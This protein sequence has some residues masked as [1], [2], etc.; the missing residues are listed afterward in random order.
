MEKIDLETKF[1][2]YGDIANERE[3]TGKIS[4]DVKMVAEKVNE[5]VEWIN[6]K[7]ENDFGLGNIKGL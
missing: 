3:A 7:K 4:P 6:S 1:K 2:T 5:I